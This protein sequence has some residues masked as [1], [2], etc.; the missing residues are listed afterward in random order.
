M[1]K[2]LAELADACRQLPKKKSEN[3]FIGDYTPEMDDTPAFKQ[4]L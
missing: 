3:P 2:Y 4:D 1:E